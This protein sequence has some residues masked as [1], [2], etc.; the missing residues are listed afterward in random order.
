LYK[1]AGKEG[2]IEDIART[3]VLMDE[4]LLDSLRERILLRNSDECLADYDSVTRVIIF[5]RW[6]ESKP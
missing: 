2:N 1:S 3:S 4:P 5:N 6:L